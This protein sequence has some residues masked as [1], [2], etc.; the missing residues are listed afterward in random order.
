MVAKRA[1]ALEEN[2]GRTPGRVA[3]KRQHGRLSFGYGRC[4]WVVGAE[5][6]GTGA[7]E[8]FDESLEPDGNVG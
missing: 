5:L 1:A 4:W 8:R 2:D 6:I 3:Q 7:T